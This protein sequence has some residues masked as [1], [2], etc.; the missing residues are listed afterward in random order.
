MT[1]WRLFW[2]L[3]S[4]SLELGQPTTVRTVPKLWY[5]SCTKRQTGGVKLCIG[6]FHITAGDHIIICW[7]TTKADC[8]H[9]RLD[10]WSITP[11]CISGRMHSL[12]KV[13]SL[14]RTVWWWCLSG[15]ILSVTITTLLFTL[16]I[17]QTTKSVFPIFESKQLLWY[18]II[19]CCGF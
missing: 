3:L 9:N 10:I 11:P 8:I 6:T 7:F 19:I 15:R 12:Q 14:R 16:S 4:L 5:C 17:A 1:G 18:L 2:L 13:S